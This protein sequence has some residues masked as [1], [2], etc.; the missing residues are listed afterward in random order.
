MKTRQARSPKG[1][2]AW[3]RLLWPRSVNGLVSKRP[4]RRGESSRETIL[5][6]ERPVAPQIRLRRPQQMSAN[7]LFSKERFITALRYWIP[8]AVVTTGLVGLVYLAVQQDL[9]MG[10]NDVPAQIAQ[11]TAASIAKGSEPWTVTGREDIEISTG[12]AAWSLVFDDAGKVVAG[13]P[14]LDGKQALPPA[15]VFSVAKA[16]GEDRV[17]WQPRTGVRQAVVA[18]RIAGGKGVVMAG[19]SLRETESHIDQLT[20]IAGAAWI[21]IMAAAFVASLLFVSAPMTLPSRDGD[22]A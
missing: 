9:R 1:L 12:L 21:A 22:E 6:S 8:L 19:H 16:S 2:L 11:D 17:T 7:G 10:A 15:G 3:F 14:V 20:Q 5:T 13:T 18:V 4:A